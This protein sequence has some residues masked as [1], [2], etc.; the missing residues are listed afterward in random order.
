MGPF[1]TPA[2]YEMM[3]HIPLSIPTMGR[4]R[5]ITTVP[6][7]NARVHNFTF[8][9]GQDNAQVEEK[10]ANKQTALLRVSRAGFKFKGN[11]RPTQ[12][13]GAIMG[14]CDQ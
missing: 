3:P 12:H 7:T 14:S 9:D 6:R 5:L 4:W 13:N 11:R 8:T 10:Q 1:S 2:I